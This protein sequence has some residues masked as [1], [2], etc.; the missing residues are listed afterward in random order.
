MT[1]LLD[2]Q[3]KCKKVFDAPGSIKIRKCASVLGERREWGQW[4]FSLERHIAVA[5]TPPAGSWRAGWPSPGP[6][7]S[8][9]WGLL[10]TNYCGFLTGL[11]KM[12]KMSLFFWFYFVDLFCVFSFWGYEKWAGVPGWYTTISVGILLIPGTQRLAAMATIK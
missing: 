6:W 3:N 4:P 10:H 12:I 8:P 11:K 5:P 1:Y 2:F 7:L 9:Q